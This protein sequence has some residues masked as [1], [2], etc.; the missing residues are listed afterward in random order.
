MLSLGPYIKVSEHTVAYHHLPQAHGP[1][2]VVPGRFQHRLGLVVCHKIISGCVQP[3]A[4][5]LLLQESPEVCKLGLVSWVPE[6]PPVV[7]YELS[8]M[9]SQGITQVSGIHKVNANSVLV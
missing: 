6:V 5:Y 8:R 9:G 1:P 4:C 2:R 7:L 3:K